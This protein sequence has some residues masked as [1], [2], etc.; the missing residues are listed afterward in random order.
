MVLRNEGCCFLLLQ[1]GWIC[2]NCGFVK[3][4]VGRWIGFGRFWRCVRGGR[5]LVGWV[6]V[7]DKCGG[8]EDGRW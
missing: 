8:D 7:Y 5:W 6:R 1:K 4:G 2:F 3:K